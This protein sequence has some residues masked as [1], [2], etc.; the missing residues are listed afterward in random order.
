MVEDIGHY[1]TILDGILID[2]ECGPSATISLQN[3]AP[4]THTLI[5]VPALNNHHEIQGGAA[6]LTFEYAPSDPLPEIV[7]AEPAAPPTITIVSPAAGTAVSGEFEIQVAVTDFTLSE[8]LYGKPDLA[9]YGHWHANVDSTDG[10]MMGMVTMLG[11]S[12]SETFTASTQGLEPG[13]HTFFA[14]L[15]GNQHMPFMEPVMA[16]VEL[17]VE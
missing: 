8:A 9:G 6:M 13:P 2:M 5:A 12:G 7:A 4:G 16:S 10:P 3:V 1:H 11:M 14:V 15:V 17:V